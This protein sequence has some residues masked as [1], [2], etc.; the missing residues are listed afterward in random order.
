VSAALAR[1]RLDSNYLAAA[2]YLK[3]LGEDTTVP[4]HIRTLCATFAEK[5]GHD[6]ITLAYLIERYQKSKTPW[7]KDMF[8]KRISKIRF[9]D[10]EGDSA[11]PILADEAT[12]L[13]A[14]SQILRMSERAPLSELTSLLADIL[15]PN[16]S[17]AGLRILEQLKRQPR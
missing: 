5:G 14:V 9:K 15:S 11:N 8:V 13:Q 17:P 7:E 16:P 1:V 6:Q 12:R 10:L 3:P 2:E 4:S